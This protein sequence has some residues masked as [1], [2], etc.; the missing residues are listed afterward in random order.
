VKDYLQIIVEQANRLNQLA[1]DTL[2]ITK[3]ESGQLSYYFKIVN[4][5]RLIQDA[6]SMV[7]LSS[8]HK[9][10]YTIDPK[11]LF[12]RGDQT[13][14]RQVIQNLVSNAVKYSPKGGEVKVTAEEGKEET[15]LV[16]VADEG[17]GIP[18]DQRDKL[19]QKFSRVQTGEAKD[20]KGAGL[21]LWICKEV[22]E[23]HGG[24]IWI[25]SELGRG[26]TIRFT[27]NRAQ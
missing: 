7:R 20:I 17:I 11:I 13:K 5:E 24:T 2:S 9:I 8:R 12:I 1:E 4:L 16:S 15:I 3:L 10:G 6:I 19:F 27:L 21:G 25:E 22:V 23:A 18:A 26:S 14:L